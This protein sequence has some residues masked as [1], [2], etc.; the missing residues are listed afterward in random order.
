M[1]PSVTRRFAAAL[2]TVLGACTL[3]GACA[4]PAQKAVIRAQRFDL[5]PLPSAALAPA[6]GTPSAAPLPVLKIATVDAPADLS[7]D[8]IRYRLRYAGER[9]ANLYTTSRWTMTP[10][11]MLTQR[12]RDSLATRYTV[13]G[14]GEPVKAPLLAVQ[15]VEFAQWFDAPRES[16]GVVVLRVSLISDGQVRA[17]RTFQ[18]SEPSRS[19]DAAGGVDALA[20]ATDASCQDIAAWLGQVRPAS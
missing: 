11:Q 10:A 19:A 7:S 6:A 17:Q 15:L 8:Q 16:R 9:E 2:A 3:L 4:A 20:R 18:R 12:L 14:G 5:G 1:T 13:L